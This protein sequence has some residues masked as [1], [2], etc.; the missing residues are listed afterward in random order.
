MISAYKT[1]AQNERSIF[2]FIHSNGKHSLYDFINKKNKR[3]YEIS[4]FYEY[5]NTHLEHYLS[6]S[7]LYSEW[8]MVHNALE[9]LTVSLDEA[10]LPYEIISRGLYWPKL[11]EVSVV[12]T[13][14]GD[15]TVLEASH[16]LLTDKIPL[17]GIRSSAMSVGLLCAC[18]QANVP[19]LVKQLKEDGLSYLKVQRL[20]AEITY[21]QSG[22]KIVTDPILN[23][24]LFA[25]KS[26]ALTSRYNVTY[27]Q[28]SEDQ[29]SSGVWVSTAIGSTAA[30]GAA[31][32]KLLSREDKRSQFL[33]RE[34][35]QRQNHKK[36]VLDSRLFDSDSDR[37]AITNHN[38]EAMLALDGQH[39]LISLTFGDH[40][41]FKKASAL[42]LL[43]SV[44]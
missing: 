15:G 33:V 28:V 32:G 20:C 13:V 12:M 7:N 27:K 5:V 4:D 31:G 25:N 30:I 26:P 34:L 10:R 38:D 40:I 9:Q 44:E 2:S 21:A 19:S 11:K 24:F 14:G 22:T 36:L 16:H 39:G 6:D 1:F 35:Y 17:I 42:S 3:L 37:L 8:L 41:V 43:E 29:K 23:D 18:S